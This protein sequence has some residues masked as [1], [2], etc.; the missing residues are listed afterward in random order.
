MSRQSLAIAAILLGAFLRFYRIDAQSFWNDEG[1]SAR[2]AERSVQLIIEGATGDIHPPGYYLLLAAWRAAAGHSEFALRGLSA[3]AGI[4]LV[5][6][7]YRLGQRYFDEPAALCAAF[8]AAVHPAL[9]YYSQEARMYEWAALWGAAAFLAID[10]RRLEI[11][12]WRFAIILAAGLYTHYSFAF[13]V[14]ALNLLFLARITQLAITN[15]PS[16]N[17]HSLL[18]NLFLP[19]LFAL[20]LFSPWLPIALRQITSW[21]AAREYLPPLDSLIGV[22]RWMTVGATIDAAAATPAILGVIMLLLLG[23]RRRGQILAPLIWL[24]APSVATV[25]LGLFSATF[26]KFLIVGVPALCLI[27]GNGA[28]GIFAREAGEPVS[29]TRGLSHGSTRHRAVAVPSLAGALLVGITAAASLSNLYFNP[30]Y[31]RADYRGIVRYLDSIA[32]P[33]DAILLNAP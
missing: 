26:A 13:I 27:I 4:V 12:D 18:L 6:L 8:F 30:T 2:I 11:G 29:L 31:A 17:L 10:K 19:Q 22:T 23:L 5:A 20:L 15:N 33:G 32:K 9:I 28:A 14:I 1:N 21:P 7:V 16:S 3:L 24:L 25:A